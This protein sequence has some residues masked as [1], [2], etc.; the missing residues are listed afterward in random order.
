LAPHGNDGAG[1]DPVDAAAASTA[2][3]PAELS[4]L[5]ELPM[6]LRLPLRQIAASFRR[7]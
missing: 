6:F 2:A 1:G 5:F 4:G 3:D 7:A